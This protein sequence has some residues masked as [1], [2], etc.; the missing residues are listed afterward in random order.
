MDPELLIVAAAVAL[1][2]ALPVA[3]LCWM[4][5]Q[6]AYGRGMARR[7]D[8]LEAAVERLSDARPA[9]A[10]DPALAA[11]LFAGHESERPVDEVALER[12]DD[13]FDVATA[14]EERVSARVVERADAAPV[15][16]PPPAAAVEPRRDADD[17]LDAP[18]APSDAP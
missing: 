14:R 2:F 15:V 6:W 1:V 5:A 11:A 4:A 17:E 18:S 16:I 10:G 13:D 9:I 12:L 7:I 8:A 3:I